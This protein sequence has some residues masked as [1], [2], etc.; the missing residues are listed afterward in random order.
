MSVALKAAITMDVDTLES[1]YKGQGCRRSSGYTHAEMR[2]GLENF[3]HFLEPYKAN[4][5]L[6]MVGNDFRYPENIAPINAMAE[7]GNEIANHTL[8]H[9]QGFRLLSL[10]EKELELAGM[11]ELCQQKIGCRPV[12][13][14][15]PGWN[16]GDDALP[17]LQRRGYLYDS[18]VFPTF[19][20]PLLKTMH[21]YT[22]RSRAGI[23]RT[24]L[25]HMKYMFAPVVPYRT[26]STS[27][28]ERGDGGLIEFPVTVTPFFRLPFFAT[29]LVS[30]GMGVFN[31]SLKAI[32]QLKRP[33]QFQFHLSDFV[34]YDHPD[35]ADQVPIDGQGVYIPHALRMPLANKLAMF[36][37][38][39]N[40]IA[41]DYEFN[42]LAKWGNTLT[43][44]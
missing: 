34:D 6:F 11:E 31:M 18:S 40:A 20:T 9:A 12:G 30:T 3:S 42:T 21:W 33:L 26:S 1:I 17:I 2:I 32:R 22:M 44:Q 7:A 41:Q 29:F 38:V 24:T 16:I 13:F 5:T 36:Q 10:A 15:S 27:L 23:E 43:N 8:T 35:L 14:R 4:A 25:G 39:M 19:L 37:Q 28:S